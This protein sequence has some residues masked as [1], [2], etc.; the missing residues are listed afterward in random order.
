MASTL[1]ACIALAYLSSWSFA[2]IAAQGNTTCKTT[3]LDW[4]TTTVGETP[5]QTY[6]RLRQICNSAYTVGSL[7]PSTPPD[8]CNDQVGGCCCNSI[9][10]ALSMLC[11]NCQQGVGSGINGDSGI[12]AGVGAYQDYLGTCAPNVN[13]S[14]PADIQAAVCNNKIK[15]DNDLYTLFWGDGSWF[16]IY[17]RETIQKNQQTFANNTYTHC[18]STTI[19][20]STTSTSAVATFTPTSSAGLPGSTGSSDHS[21]SSLSGGTVVGI[22]VGS[23]TALL[24]L[25]GVLIWFLRKRRRDALLPDKI[26]S[27]SPPEIEQVAYQIEPFLHSSSGAASG[28]LV[29]NNYRSS[30]ERSEGNS[31][32]LPSSSGPTQP[33]SRSEKNRL[34]MPDGDNISTGHSLSMSSTNADPLTS[35]SPMSSDALAERHADA[36]PLLGRSPSGRLPPAYGEQ[37]DGV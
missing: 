7:S 12:D 2:I 37:R 9:S 18:A 14:L 10:F 35:P 21:S 11:L 27:L 6:Q 17:T 36:G 1:R 15:V 8:T 29:S 24:S 19:N 4:Y 33:P 31:R 34:I 25:I 13:Q 22:A 3:S 28:F 32:T 20:N 26:S 5:C 23:M 16:Y 30:L